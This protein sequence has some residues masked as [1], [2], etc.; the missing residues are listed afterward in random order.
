MALFDVENR[1]GSPFP[2]DRFTLPDPD[3]KTGIR[4]NLTKPDCDSR[5]TDCQDI[6]VINT[7]DGF[8]LQ[9]RISIPFDGPI[10]L[11]SI[12]RSTVFIVSLASPPKGSHALASPPSLPLLLCL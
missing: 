11:G 3:Q 10:D 5:P 1:R 2:S 4:V 7:L 9:P 12:S 8:N 6:D